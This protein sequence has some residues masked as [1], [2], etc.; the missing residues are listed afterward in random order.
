[1]AKDQ[2]M[3]GLRIARRT[4]L[5][6][7]VGLAA[8]GSTT[9]ALGGAH[10][11]SESGPVP[12]APFKSMRDYI[13]ALEARG[14]VVRIPRVDQDAYEATALMYRMRD[15]HGMRGAP[16]MIFDEVRIDGKWVKGPLVINESGNLDG[17]CLVFGLEPISEAPLTRAPY[18]SYRRAR[19]HVEALLAKTD[20]AY[21]GIAPVE[22]TRDQAVCKEVVLRGDEIDLTKFAFIKGNPGDAG[23]YINTGSVFTRDPRQGVNF[24]TYRCHLR[25][26]RELALNSEPGQTGYR[27]M[28][29]ARKRGEKTMQVAIALTADPYFWMVSSSKMAFNAEAKTDEIEMGIAGGL[30]GQPIEV[31]RCE[32]NDFRVPAWAEMIIE[33]EVPLEEM[34]PEGPYAEMVG[35]QGQVKDE[36]FWVRVTAVTHRRNPWL[37]NNFTGVQAGSLMSASHAGAVYRLRKKFPYVVDWL[38]DTRAVGLTVVSIN[39][40]EAGQGIE[41]AEHIAKRAFFA[42]VVI[43]VDDDVDI[44]DHEAVFAAMGARW[45]PDGNTRTYPPRPSMPLDPSNTAP[46]RGSKIAIDATRALPGEG[47]KTPWPATNRS[48]LETGAPEAIANVDQKWGE[49]IKGWQ[50]DA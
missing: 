24:G 10:E 31:V 35:Y 8:L 49:L 6:T 4:L 5:Q 2:S 44:S 43:V 7:S 27:H 18:Q 11:K 47:R 26:P 22:V 14:L 48:L 36:V 28:M 45:Q 20:G 32:T 41:V 13:A 17:E 33:G 1:M 30:A 40:T 29:A 42:K 12:V 46:G 15:E 38:S 16:A 39:K 25:G 37:M 34:R 21:P 9:A 50:R 3:D 23:R 19:E